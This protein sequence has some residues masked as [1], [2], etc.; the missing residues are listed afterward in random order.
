MVGQT[1]QGSEPQTQTQMSESNAQMSESKGP[2]R[3]MTEMAVGVSWN[4]NFSFRFLLGGLKKFL[5]VWPI[6]RALLW[7]LL[8]KLG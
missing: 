7:P 1:C 4:S 6:I 5:T 3:C 8:A 2:A